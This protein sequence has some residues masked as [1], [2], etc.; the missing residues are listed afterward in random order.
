MFRQT[1]SNYEA[2]ELYS[3]RLQFCKGRHNWWRILWGLWLS[4]GKY[5]SII[6]MKAS[7][8]WRFT[9]PQ[10]NQLVYTHKKCAI[11]MFVFMRLK[12]L[13]FNYFL[14]FNV[15]RQIYYKLLE[16]I[17]FASRFSLLY[18]PHRGYISF[19]NTFVTHRNND[20]GPYVP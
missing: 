4:L 17:S 18:P 1:E 10:Y 12:F 2:V 13:Y 9:S 19:V 6:Q 3:K 7:D 5:S 16:F 8:W 14:S 20:L 15:L 11:V